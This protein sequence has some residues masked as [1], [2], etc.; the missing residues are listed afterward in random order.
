M[1]STCSRASFA[2]AITAGPTVTVV[3]DPPAM[4]AYGA[5]SLLPFSTLI[6]S[7]GVPNASAASIAKVVFVPVMSEWPSWSEMVPSVFNRTLAA[8]G[9]SPPGQPPT[10]IPTALFDPL[11]RFFQISWFWIVSST[12]FS[13]IRGQGPPCAC[14]CP[15]SDAFLSRNSTGSISSSTA[16]SSIA[17][18]RANVA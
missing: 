14:G 18:S 1:A 16:S 3:F 9:S 8:H 6:F 7:I 15:S 10:A 17:C 5:A 13:P 12:S 2:A 4:P 11:C